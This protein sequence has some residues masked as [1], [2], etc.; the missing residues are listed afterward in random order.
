MEELLE[1][2]DKRNPTT[3]NELSKQEKEEYLNDFERE[4]QNLIEAY[5]NLGIEPDDLADILNNYR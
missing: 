5:E 4:V 1:F 2:M 3:N